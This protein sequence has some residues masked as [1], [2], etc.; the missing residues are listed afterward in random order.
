MGGS[1]PYDF[2][3]A[4]GP[5]TP[6]KLTLATIKMG[7]GAMLFVFLTAEKGGGEPSNDDSR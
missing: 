1:T 7:V 5:T 6:K 2:T 3:V 4:G